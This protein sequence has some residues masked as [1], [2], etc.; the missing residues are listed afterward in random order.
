MF[1]DRNIQNH[2]VIEPEY[3]M[4]L[5]VYSL[6]KD[7]HAGM[8][9]GVPKLSFERLQEYLALFDKTFEVQRNV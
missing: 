2:D 5:P 3:D 7:V 9:E 6:Y 4:K 1:Y 8:R